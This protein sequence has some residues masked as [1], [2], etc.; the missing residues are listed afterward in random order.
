MQAPVPAAGTAAPATAVSGTIGSPRCAS[1]RG[2]ARHWTLPRTATSTQVSRL[3]PRA[4]TARL[5]MV[6]VCGSSYAGCGPFGAA[7]G[8]A[9]RSEVA[10]TV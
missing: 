9:A 1:H 4:L 2:G 7:P 6:K 10:E 3:R 5:G 8:L